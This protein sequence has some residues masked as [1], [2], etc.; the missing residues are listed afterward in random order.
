MDYYRECCCI[1]WK[2]FKPADDQTRAWVLL[3]VACV[4][5]GVNKYRQGPV[6]EPLFARFDTPAN[7]SLPHTL[8]S[9]DSG[10][11]AHVSKDDPAQVWRQQWARLRAYHR[12]ASATAQADRVK[13]LEARLAA[14]EQELARGKEKIQRMQQSF[15]WQST[16]WLRAMRRVL[17]D[18]SR[19]RVPVD[20]ALDMPESWEAAPAKGRIVG[21]C[22]LAGGVP[23][24]AVRARID[25]RVFPAT[26]DRIFRP[27]VAQSNGWAV[28]DA[29]Y[30]FEIAYELEPEREYAVILEVC[31]PTGRWQAQEARPLRTSRRPV[32]RDYATW[33]DR[34]DRLTPEKASALRAKLGALAPDQNPRIS[35]LMPVYNAPERW[36]V[37][38]I[39]SVR[40]QVYENWELCIADDASPA[41]HVREVLAR[42]AQ[43]DAR[44]KVVHRETNGHISRAS[45]SALELAS[46]EWVA[47]LDHDDELSPDALACVVLNHARRPDVAAWYSDEDKIDEEGQ[48]FDPYFKPDYLPDLLTGQNCLSHLS[49]FRTDLIRAVGGFRVGYEGSQDWDLALRVVEQ[50]RPEQVGHI[51]KVL[52]HWRA[53]RGSTALANTEKDY[54]VGAA[55]RALQDHFQRRGV[56]VS[57]QPVPG[58]HWRAIYPMPARAPMV[59][60][61]IPSYNAAGYLRQCLGSIRDLTDYPEYEII[62]VN[63]RS[64]DPDA[65]ALLHWIQQDPAIRVLDYPAPFN[66]S[67]INNF[68]VRHARGALVCLLNNDIEVITPGWLREMVSHATRPEIGAVGAMLY[69]PDD[70]IQHAGVFLGLGGVAAHAFLHAPRGSDGQKNRARLI[71]NYSAVTAACLLIRRALFEEV[72]GFNERELA[73]A[74]NDVDFCLRIRRA[75]YRNLWTPFAELYHHE[76][77]S[78]GLDDTPEKKHRFDAEVDYMKRTWGELLAADPAYNTNLSLEIE[79]M[80][81]AW[82]PRTQAW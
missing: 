46:G 7:M 24:S 50:L 53:I 10:T 34:Y 65:L 79:G 52:Y 48:R 27:D 54:T 64:D 76:S 47:L 44:I 20:L 58:H 81:L 74:F 56:A 80:Q 11:E 2:D 30:G 39:E 12:P 4:C 75:G 29:P 9:L 49:V 45:N 28:A 78:R 36:L 22:A 6:G 63:N 62:V 21:W 60:I 59:S 40:E 70:T 18:R 19:R 33:V 26:K 73:V 15:S 31:L 51:P 77:I 13:D 23:V 61:I 67:A 8:N 25:G 14:A 66:Y 32:Q 3:P 5:G 41:A 1:A 55:E 42:Y 71:Q 35:I 16:G 43:Q 82:P 72:G 37:R 17:L 69:Y 38:A 57:L 68:A